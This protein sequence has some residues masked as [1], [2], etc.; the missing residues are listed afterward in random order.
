VVHILIKYRK[1]LDTLN[2]EELDNINDIVVLDFI[3]SIID[4]YIKDEILIKEL[5][6]IYRKWLNKFNE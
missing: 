2:K 1:F 3:F 4:D 6:E 5:R